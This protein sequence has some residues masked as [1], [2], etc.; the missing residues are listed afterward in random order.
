MDKEDKIKRGIIGL[1]MDD[2]RHNNINDY[3]EYYDYCENKFDKLALEKEIEKARAEAIGWAYADCC[4]TLDNGGDP[5]Q[6][7][8]S[9]VLERANKDLSSEV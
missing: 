3:N 1:S 5:R 4:I 6:T 2:I 8:M 9:D 7:E